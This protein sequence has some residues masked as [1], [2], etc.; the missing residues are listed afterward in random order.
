MTLIQLLICVNMFGI[1]GNLIKII[2]VYPLMLLGRFLAGLAGGVSQ[3]LL[4]KFI[5]ETV[6]T[7]TLQ[8]YG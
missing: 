7:E 4:S 2:M 8:V 3:V 6:P 1:M 5:T